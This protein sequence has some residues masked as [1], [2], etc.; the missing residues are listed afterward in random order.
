M[1]RFDTREEAEKMPL[2]KALAIDEEISIVC[3]GDIKNASDCVACCGTHPS[4]AGQVGLI[5]LYKVCLLYT[6]IEGKVL[7]H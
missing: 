7:L 4:S 6:S 3:V 1:L 5:K 2:R